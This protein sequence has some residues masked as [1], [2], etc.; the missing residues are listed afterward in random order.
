M[1]CGIDALAAFGAVGFHAQAQEELARWLVTQHRDAEA[2]PL[3]DA[4]RA[5]YADI[6]ATGWLTR[7]DTW[8]P[9]HH[10]TTGSPISA[11]ATTR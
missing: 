4:A 1:R 2:T 11:Q 9:T 10:P 6:G 7:L 3:L 8:Q 5:T